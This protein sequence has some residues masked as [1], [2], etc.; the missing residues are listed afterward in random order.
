MKN[1]SAIQRRAALAAGIALGASVVSGGA[2]AQAAYPGSAPIKMLVGNPAGGTTDVVG[3]MIAAKM[4]EVLKASVIVD[5][6]PGAS[7]LIAAEAVAKAPADGYTILMASSGLATL[8]ALYP[9]STFDA[10]KDLEPIGIIA[11]S[12]YVM[13][14]H[15]SMPVKTLPELLAYARANPGKISYA[16]S[17]PG[18]AQHL[19]WELI[20]RITNTD[21]QYVPYKGTGALMPDLLAGRLQAGIDNVAILTPY[22][23]AGQLRGIAVTSA[24]PSPLLPDL[25]TVASA[26][27]PDFSAVGWFVVFAPPKT[28]A[29]VLAALRQ[30]VKETMA[31]PDTRDKLVGI[32]AEPQS[33]S[34]EEGRALLKRETTVW[35]K[36]IKESGITVQ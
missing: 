7:G 24:K 25:P 8:R 16:G 34:Y 27:V 3:R 30:A 4:G 13:V 18:T 15:P 28:P 22:I 10:E 26:G 19:G 6:K 31:S 29:P 21:M 36:V 17:T 1:F 12:P 35:T 23:K 11:T 9:A 20:K 5:N 14:V 33:G 32:G 2:F